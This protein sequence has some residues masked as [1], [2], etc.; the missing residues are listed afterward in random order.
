LFAFLGLIWHNLIS[1]YDKKK[2]F[3]HQIMNILISIFY[4][5]NGHYN[6]YIIFLILLFL[7]FF[8]PFV[9]YLLFYAKKYSGGN[10]LAADYKSRTKAQKI[11]LFISIFLLIFASFLFYRLFVLTTLF[12]FPIPDYILIFFNS[13]LLGL[14]KIGILK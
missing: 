5:L 3:T 8:L 6:P 11:K 13:I 9:F 10:D 4:R 1:R 12:D 7:A 14:E 2:E